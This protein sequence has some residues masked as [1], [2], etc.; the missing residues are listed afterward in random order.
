MTLPMGSNYE[1]MQVFPAGGSSRKVSATTSDQ[2]FAFV[3]TSVRVVSVQTDVE[4]YIAFGGSSV[5]TDVTSGLGTDTL[6]LFAGESFTLG[7]PPGITHYAVKLPTGT[8]NVYVR[9]GGE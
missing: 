1:L 9:E 7:L 4:A 6:I 3:G 8:G 2:V 5:A